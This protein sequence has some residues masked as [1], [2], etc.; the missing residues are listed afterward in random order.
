[1]ANG[2]C[3]KHFPKP[4]RTR[5]IV[6]SETSYPV[7]QRCSPE[8]GGASAIKNGKFID[9]SYIVPFSP[10]LISRY[11][12]HIN[13]EICISALASKYLFKY[14]TKG[15]D[16]AMVAIQVP[17]DDG[18]PPRNEIKDYEDMCSIGS[19]EASWRLSSFPIAENKPPVQPLCIHLK[20]QQH[21]VFVGGEEEHVVERGRE[22]ELTAFFKY[23][24]EEKERTGPNFDPRVLPMYVDMPQTYTFNN[25]K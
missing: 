9:N 10:Y 2:K 24:A 11:Q 12:C 13:V 3:A 25:K 8:Q 18:A 20:D 19:S 7:H 4:F 21:V 6:D 5:T 15:P 22:T 16:R 17:G 23:N 1:M 14:V